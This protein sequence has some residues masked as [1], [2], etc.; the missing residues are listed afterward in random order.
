VLHGSE[1]W[2]ARKDNQLTLQQA[3]LRMIRWMCGVKVTDRFACSELRERL[4]IDDTISVVQQH[5]LR[6]YHGHVLRNNKNDWVE[7]A[8]IMKWKV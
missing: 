4:G 7:N 5:R 3:E 2:P 6:W 1:M 8:W